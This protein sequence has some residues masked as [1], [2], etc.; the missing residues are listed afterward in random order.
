MIAFTA[1]VALTSPSAG[2]DTNAQNTLAPRLAEAVE[3]RDAYDSEKAEAILAEECDANKPGACRMLMALHRNLYD[4]EAQIRA[5]ARADAVCADGD[6]M[7]CLRIA[8]MAEEGTGGPRDEKAVRAGFTR[9]CELGHG[10]ACER[11]AGMNYDARGGDEDILQ[12]TALAEAGCEL[13]NAK[14]CGYAG[15]I[16][17]SA[18]FEIGDEAGEAATTLFAKARSFYR[19]ACDLGDSYSC[20]ELA[21]LLSEGRGGAADWAASKALH[22]KACRVDLYR[23]D[24]LLK[25]Q[26]PPRR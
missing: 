10:A 17:N 18:A 4:D 8:D 14:S 16:A 9:A 24:D 15:S 6:W 12:A 13:D 1:L 23:C 25:G 7:G 11:A 26:L 3:A 21:R 22:D 20:Y 19:K 2:Q 5:R